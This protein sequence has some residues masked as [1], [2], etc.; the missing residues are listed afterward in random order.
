MPECFRNALHTDSGIWIVTF[1]HQFL[2][3]NFYVGVYITKITVNFNKIILQSVAFL[4][5][6]TVKNN[7]DNWFM[8]NIWEMKENYEK[9]D[10]N[11]Q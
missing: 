8:F 10:F 11:S 5:T 1:K 4:F 9:K 2:E 3:N 7:G 6:V